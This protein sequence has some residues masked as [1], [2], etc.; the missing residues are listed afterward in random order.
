MRGANNDEKRQREESLLYCSNGGTDMYLFMDL[1]SL[2]NSFYITDLCGVFFT[3][4][5]GRE[6]RDCLH[7]LIL[8]NGNHRTSRIFRIWR[9]DRSSVRTDRRLHHRVH[10]HRSR[11]YTPGTPDEKKQNS[12][13]ACFGERTASL[14]PDRDIMVYSSVLPARQQCGILGC[15][16]YVCAA[17]YCPGLRQNH[18]GSLSAFNHKTLVFTHLIRQRAGNDTASV[19]IPAQSCFEACGRSQSPHLTFDRFFGYLVSK[20]IEHLIC[21]RSKTRQVIL[22]MF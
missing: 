7:M 19:P 5:F 2:C 12:S 16:Q 11:V 14:L 1:G 4:P 9:R 13:V 10:F 3:S 17:L 18:A 8:V 15:I 21:L 22:S 6:K 20:N